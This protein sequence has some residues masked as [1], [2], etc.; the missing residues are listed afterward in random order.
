MIFFIFSADISQLSSEFTSKNNLTIQIFFQLTAFTSSILYIIMISRKVVW[1]CHAE[2]CAETNRVK[3]GER[4]E[5]VESAINV[6][7]PLQIERS[8]CTSD[9]FSLNSVGNFFL[10]AMHFPCELVSHTCLFYQAENVQQL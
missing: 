7:L 9:F 6:I 1:D 4:R 5:V 2:S 8:Y 10:C 3:R